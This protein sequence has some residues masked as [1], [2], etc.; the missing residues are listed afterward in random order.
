M[1][2]TPVEI[3]IAALK[4]TSVQ[5]SAGRID[6][7]KE[8]EQNFIAECRLEKIDP[9]WTSIKDGVPP[10]NKGV[11]TTDGKEVSFGRITK[12]EIHRPIDKTSPDYAKYTWASIEPHILTPTH[13]MH[14][15]KTT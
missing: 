3:F 10:F 15:P 13:W 4:G 2:Q 11:L 14:L 1:K 6:E 7:I 8:Y 12:V 5:I 9:Q